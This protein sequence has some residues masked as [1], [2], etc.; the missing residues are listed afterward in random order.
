MEILP[1]NHIFECWKSWFIPV[2]RLLYRQYLLLKYK[3]YEYLLFIIIISL[4][5][6]Y[7]MSLFVKQQLFST[8][9]IVITH[10]VPCGL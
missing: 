1:P 3:H 9:Y 4:F 6:L 7:I 2:S 5:I 8:L 10:F